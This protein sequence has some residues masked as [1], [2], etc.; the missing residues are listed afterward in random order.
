MRLASFLPVL[1]AASAGQERAEA[2]DPVAEG[3]G[4]LAYVAH[5]HASRMK[6]EG[7]SAPM[8]DMA[9]CLEFQR[10]VDGR[11]GPWR[12]SPIYRQL[13][14]VESSSR[15]TALMRPDRRA[16]LR[17][18]GSPMRVAY[19]ADNWNFASGLIRALQR[20]GLE[21]VTLDAS[22]LRVSPA[23]HYPWVRPHPAAEVMST[24]RVLRERRFDS[25]LE[26]AELVIVDWAW[27]PALIMSRLLAG[28]VP[29]VIR[30]H[31]F[32]AF[33]PLPYFID[34]GAVAGIIFVSEPIRAFFLEQHRERLGHV[35]TVVAPN[36]MPRPPRLPARSELGQRLG[37]LKYADENKDPLFAIDVLELLLARDHGWTL[38]LAGDHWN[39]GE[40]DAP[41]FEEV[42]RRLRSSAIQ[43]SV[44]FD[45]YQQDPHS[46]A[47]QI[48]F[49]LSCSRREG[50]HEALMD[51]YHAGAEPVIRDWPMV[52]RYGGPAAVYPQ[53]VDRVIQSPS[54]AAELIMRL[55]QED[56]GVRG[57]TG[58]SCA[59]AGLGDAEVVRWLRELV[60]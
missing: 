44:H 43:G 28:R 52:R 25:C 33:A 1:D 42:E 14:E 40:Q 18:Q 59:A 37:M 39:R 2:V 19:V 13:T 24:S 9:D 35:R 30:V 6:A 54:E 53:W 7:R 12:Q 15:R 47:R 20:D 27:T 34:W 3:R 36:A 32:E 4:L 8:L 26:S 46:W 41:Y 22:L 11:L 23:S 49:I 31:S 58:D 50:T 48:D 29:L 5:L 60:Q 10:D 17:Q 51:G 55:R 57:G 16:G 56:P 45:G 38:R 21:V